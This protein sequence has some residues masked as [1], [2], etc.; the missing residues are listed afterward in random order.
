[1]RTIGVLLV[2]AACN[3]V[4]SVGLDA[5]GDAAPDGEPPAGGVVVPWSA[6][7]SLPGAL[8]DRIYISGATFQIAHLQVVGDAGPGDERTTRSDYQIAWGGGGPPAPETFPDAPVGVYSQATIQIGSPGIGQWAYTIDGT[9]LDDDDDD[10]RGSALKEALKPFRIVDY[11]RIDVTVAC[12][13]ILAAG[14]S[15]MVPIRLA[16]LDVIAGINF[17]LLFEDPNGVLLLGPGDPQMPALRTRLAH[18]FV[19]DRVPL[20]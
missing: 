1:M 15:A 14:G 17:D 9:W 16:L 2:F 6:R 13:N 10:V 18:A 12:D 3:Q 11:Q 5:A 8:S 20:Q 7:P 19:S 4:D